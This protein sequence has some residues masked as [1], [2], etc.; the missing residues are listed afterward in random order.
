MLQ[1]SGCYRKVQARCLMSPRSPRRLMNPCSKLTIS[2]TLSCATNVE[3]NGL[4]ED[5]WA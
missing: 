3:Q 5:L 1:L 4:Q 2:S